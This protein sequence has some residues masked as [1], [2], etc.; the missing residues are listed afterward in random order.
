M[1]RIVWLGVFIAHAISGFLLYRW[2]ALSDSHLADNDWL[3]FGLP[4]W[5]AFLT[6]LVAFIFSEYL[7]PRSL[8][9]YVA[10]TVLSFAGAAFCCLFYM[11]FAA[12]TY[13]T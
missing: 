2:R 4:F 11:F 10:L 1:L 7:R 3:V 8:Y 5:L 9:R 13:G 6:Y 12:N